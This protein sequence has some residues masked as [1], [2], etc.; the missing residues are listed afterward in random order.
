MAKVLVIADIKRGEVKRST[1]EL[2]AKP[3]LLVLRLLSLLSVTTW[4]H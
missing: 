1:A 2:L 3:E 4:K